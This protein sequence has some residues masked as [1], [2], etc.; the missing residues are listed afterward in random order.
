[1]DCCVRTHTW[2]S[3][4]PGINEPTANDPEMDPDYNFIQQTLE[5]FKDPVVLRDYRVA[6]MDRGIETSRGHS[7][8]VMYI[9]RHRRYSGRA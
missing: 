8:T 6:I 4:A 9:R 1:M 2:I 7:Q 3:P 5:I